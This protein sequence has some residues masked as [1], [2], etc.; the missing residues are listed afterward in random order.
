MGEIKLEN[1]MAKKLIQL[2][3]PHKVF[4][5]QSGSMTFF[6]AIMFTTMIGVAGIAIDIARLEA[7]SSNTWM[8]DASYTL[9]SP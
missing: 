3:K 8:E 6:V 7:R 1:V 9:N 5:D 2:L 4:K